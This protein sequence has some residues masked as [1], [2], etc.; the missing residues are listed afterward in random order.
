MVL[1]GVNENDAFYST[2]HHFTN[3][4]ALVFTLFDTKGKNAE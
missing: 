2:N 4:F 1:V 3:T